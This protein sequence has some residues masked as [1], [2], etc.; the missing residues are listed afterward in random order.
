MLTTGE[1]LDLIHTFVSCVAIRGETSIGSVLLVFDSATINWE[2]KMP[3][4]WENSLPHSGKNKC[5]F[6]GKVLAVYNFW[7]FTGACF[8]AG[9]F[10]LLECT[11]V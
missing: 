1:K 7:R 10:F 4:T 8:N 11:F 5:H 2:N 6:S 3:Q 9:V